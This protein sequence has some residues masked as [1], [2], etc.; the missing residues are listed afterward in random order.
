ML[1]ERELALLQQGLPST[2]W[3]ARVPHIENIDSWPC[4]GLLP[5][6]SAWSLEELPPFTDPRWEVLWK[7]ATT[8]SCAAPEQQALTNAFQ[9]YADRH[10]WAKEDATAMVDY[11]R[12][13]DF[14]AWSHLWNSEHAATLNT[15]SYHLLHMLVAHPQLVD[16]D[17]S[18]LTR[19]STYVVDTPLLRA[20]QKE[21]L[22][23]GMLGWDDKQWAHHCWAT[24]EKQLVD[25]CAQACPHRRDWFSLLNTNTSILDTQFGHED[26]HKLWKQSVETSY[27]ATMEPYDLTDSESAW[28]MF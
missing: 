14:H 3:S 2:Y 26:L 16:S 25:L 4:F 5:L 27:A 15:W 24:Q 6:A 20:G 9:M 23:I 19:I 17:A 11:L 12:N 28:N 13:H 21:M 22:L 10:K 7:K 1:A 8:W 18:A